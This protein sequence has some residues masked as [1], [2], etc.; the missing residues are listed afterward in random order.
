MK[1]AVTTRPDRGRNS[2]VTRKRFNASRNASRP[3]FVA[4]EIPRG[5]VATPPRPT[6]S[7]VGKKTK[8]YWTL[9]HGRAGAS[10][11]LRYNIILPRDTR[12]TSSRETTARTADCGRIPMFGKIN[13]S[14]RFRSTKVCS[15]TDFRRLRYR[16]HESSDYV[17]NR[18]PFCKYVL[19]RR[20]H[21]GRSD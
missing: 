7:T 13:I 18:I 2:Y 6:R 5:D 15:S 3:D 10:V 19:L 12:T 20:R 21:G 9:C 8:R 14:R 1:I 11:T 17:H 4:R 16:S